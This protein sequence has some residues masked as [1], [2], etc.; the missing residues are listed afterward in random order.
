VACT[1]LHD[2]SS[3]FLPA[4]RHEAWKPAYH[5]Y[6]FEIDASAHDFHAPTSV[7]EDLIA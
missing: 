7:Y 3:K 4:A 6:Y 5:M 2:L 1:V